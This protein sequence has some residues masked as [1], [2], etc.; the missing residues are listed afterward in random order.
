MSQCTHSRANASPDQGAVPT[1]GERP[2]VGRRPDPW[3]RRRGRPYAPRTG[4]R[5]VR[6]AARR[7]PPGR[8]PRAVLWLTPG[9]GGGSAAPEGG[10][11]AKAGSVATRPRPRPS[12][13]ASATST[14]RKP[15]NMQ[16]TQLWWG[17]RSGA[18]CW[19]RERSP[20]VAAVQAGPV[21]FTE[22]GARK[23]VGPASARM[24]W[25]RGTRVQPRAVRPSLDRDLERA[26]GLLHQFQA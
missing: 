11:A 13:M 12:M 24:A 14:R 6:P 21:F 20:S 10:G 15:S 26:P 8:W 22:A 1:A 19:R 2:Q 5:T 3:L 17:R 4:R 23:C 7:R 18:Q 25:S 16:M 9:A